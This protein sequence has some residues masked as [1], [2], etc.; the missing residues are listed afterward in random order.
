M[1]ITRKIAVSLVLGAILLTGKVNAVQAYENPVAG[2]SISVDNTY[3][4]TDGAQNNTVD[5]STTN[6]SSVNDNL[7]YAKVA[8]YVNIRKSPSATSPILGKLY[9][10]TAITIISEGNGWDKVT[11]GTITGYIYADYLITDDAAKEIANS[12]SAIASNTESSVV[13]STDDALSSLGSN[14]VAYA[15]QFI[16]NRY[17]YGGTSLTLGTDCSGFTMSIYAHFGINLTRTS[18]SQALSGTKVSINNLK[19]GDLVFYAK[20]G[21]INHVAIYISNGKVISA[22]SPKTG[23]KV[24]SL[25]YRTPCKAVRYINS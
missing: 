16:G 13:S 5:N 20:G 21:R 14:I 24:S 17:I 4:N 1:N 3:Q 10:N 11:T 8:N 25:Y 15:K 18:R 22:S 2:I 19:S 23:I 9:K 12:L 7:A 6:L